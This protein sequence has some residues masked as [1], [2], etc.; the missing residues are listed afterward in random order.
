MF[1]ENPESLIRN[2]HDISKTAYTLLIRRCLWEGAAGIGNGTVRHRMALV[3]KIGEGPHSENPAL[4][5]AIIA[6]ASL[7]PAAFCISMADFGSSAGPE[8]LPSQKMIH[9]G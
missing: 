4:D 2:R 1:R 6:G 3:T 9:D 8:P 7:Y 5:Q